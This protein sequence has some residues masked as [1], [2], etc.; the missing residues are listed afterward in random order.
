[1]GAIVR[2]A[3]HGSGAAARRLGLAALALAF[4][5]ALLLAPGEAR[6]QAGYECQA[7]GQPNDRGTITCANRAYSSAISHTMSA[8]AAFLSL[9]VG[10]GAATTITATS[11]F[12]GIALLTNS[13]SASGDLTLTVSSAGAVVI[14]E[15]TGDSGGALSHG[16]HMV[17]RGGGATTADVRSGVTIGAAATPMLNRGIYLE[18]N[19]DAANRGGGAASLTSGAEIHTARQG[20][21][22]WRSGSAQTG[23]ATTITNTGAISSAQAGIFLNYEA[24]ATIT[25]TGGATIANTGAITRCRAPPTA[26]T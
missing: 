11:N 19:R 4:L 9:T 21:Y 5:A 14:R 3:N 26:S 8:T 20:L 18:L 1:M 2:A 25:N 16:I 12:S 23:A 24:P 17:Q 7:S 6:A 13:T 15:R 22:V 10:G